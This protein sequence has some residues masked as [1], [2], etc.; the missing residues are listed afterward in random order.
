VGSYPAG[1]GPFGALDMAGNAWEWVDGGNDILRG[2]AFNDRVGGVCSARLDF[3]D[4]FGSEAVGVRI[5]L[6]QA[7]TRWTL[8]GAMTPLPRPFRRPFPRF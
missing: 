4:G 7:P 3:Y 6:P 5:V 8:A 2:G 1:T